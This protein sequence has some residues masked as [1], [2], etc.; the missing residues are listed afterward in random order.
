MGRRERGAFSAPERR[1]IRSGQHPRRPN[2][3]M[4][5]ARGRVPA[6]RLVDDMVLPP[7]DKV[8]SRALR[9]VGSTLCAR[10][11]L[12][13]LIGLGGMGAVYAGTHRNGHPVAIKVLHETV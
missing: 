9:R 4:A 7:H 13:R 10:Y 1:P 2:L 11:R 12:A 3:D 5:G 6:N 8:V